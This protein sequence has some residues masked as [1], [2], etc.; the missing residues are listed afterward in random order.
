MTTIKNMTVK[1]YAE[2]RGITPQAVGQ[3]I[4]KGHNLPGVTEVNTFG[5]A[6]VLTVDTK[7]VKK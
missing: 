1:Q 3:A 5:K 4:K 6:W 7:A 2:L